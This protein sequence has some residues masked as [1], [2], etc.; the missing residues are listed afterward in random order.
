MLLLRFVGFLSIAEVIDSYLAVS[1]FRKMFLNNCWVGYLS[2]RN[3]N[4]PLF[5]NLFL[6]SIVAT[7][8]ALVFRFCNVLYLYWAK[9]DESLFASFRG[10][11]ERSSGRRG[12]WHLAIY[13]SVVKS[14]FSVLLDAY[15]LAYTNSALSLVVFNLVIEPLAARLKRHGFSKRISRTISALPLVLLWLG[16]IITLTWL[17]YFAELVAASE[18]RENL[19]RQAVGVSRITNTL[20]WY[21]CPITKQNVTPA[22]SVFDSLVALTPR[23]GISSTT[24]F[25]LPANCFNASAGA[26][27]TRQCAA[28]MNWILTPNLAFSDKVLGAAQVQC[29]VGGPQSQ[30]QRASVKFTT[31][32][33]TD[34]VISL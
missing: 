11:F 31:S 14:L 13:I 15:L 32:I 5:K 27:A 23:T 22:T 10:Y 9:C 7:L 2:Y 29:N 34:C 4:I 18:G 19:P 26:A 25:A 12:P 33:T 20:Q 6:V 21:S 30:T 3:Y 1:L 28:Q 8:V 17:L 24:S 16:V